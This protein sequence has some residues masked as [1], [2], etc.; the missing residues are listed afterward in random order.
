QR[1]R[2]VGLL[3]HTFFAGRSAPR[4]PRLCRH[5]HTAGRTDIPGADTILPAFSLRTPHRLAA[6]PVRRAHRQGA[7]GHPCRARILLDG[8]IV[9]RHCGH[10]PFV[11]RGTVPDA[12]GHTAD[13]VSDPLAHATGRGSAH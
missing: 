2:P 10:V 1:H 8:R 11:V 9:G 3:C 12:G 5:F 6:R 7:V 13:R 4:P